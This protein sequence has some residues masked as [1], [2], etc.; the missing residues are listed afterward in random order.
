M[1]RDPALLGTGRSWRTASAP[2]LHCRLHGPRSGQPARRSIVL[3]HALG[4][5]ASLWEPLAHA[6]A[7]QHRVICHDHR[8]HG[9]SD[10][11][12]GPYTMAELADDAER[13]LAE[14]D[15]GPVVWVGL[16]LGGMVGQELALRHPQRVEALVIANSCAVYDETA[17]AAWTQRIDTIARDGLGAIVDMA[18]GR[19]FGAGFRAAQPAVVDHW[20]RR[21]LGTSTAGYLGCCH[22]IRA[23]D[24]LSRLAEL[25]IPTLV[26]AGS[27]DEATPIALSEAMHARIRDARLAVLDG[28]AHLSVLERPRDFEAV[29]GDFLNSL[30]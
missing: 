22:A 5:D 4:C 10:A 2:H 15:A 7:E 18:M 25:R 28:A 8:G 17:R 9:A 13:L 1:D 19:W 29:V 30:D 20:R 23:H 26:L 11:P 3:S 14:L 6:L 16:S 24:T 12:E 21:V 27:D